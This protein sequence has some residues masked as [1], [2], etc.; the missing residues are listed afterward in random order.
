MKLEFYTQHKHRQNIKM[1]DQQTAFTHTQY[2]NGPLI[3]ITK[4]NPINII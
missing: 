3:I 1:A 2:Q 4:D